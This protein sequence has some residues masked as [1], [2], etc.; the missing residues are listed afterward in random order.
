MAR[1]LPPREV[2]LATGPQLYVLNRAGLLDLRED[3]ITNAEADAIQLNGDERCQA[4]VK[5][6]GFRLAKRRSEGC[7]R[8]RQKADRNTE[9]P[10]DVP[11][12]TGAAPHPPDAGEGDGSLYRPA[13]AHSPGLA[14][15]RAY[16]ER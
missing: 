14:L 11:F 6:P 2:R 7:L 5:L 10:P 9:Y 12:L 15:T 1:R 8:G 13:Y 3:D 16:I 4:A